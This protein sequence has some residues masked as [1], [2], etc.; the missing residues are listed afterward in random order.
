MERLFK[1]TVWKNVFAIERLF[2]P[3]VYV[4]AIERLFNYS[5]GKCVRYGEAI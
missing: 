5:L 1:T 2:N 4:S 3:T